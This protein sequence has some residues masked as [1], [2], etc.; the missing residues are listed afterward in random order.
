MRQHKP[1]RSTAVA[2]SNK[3]LKKDNACMGGANVIINPRRMRDVNSTTSTT[4]SATRIPIRTERAPLPPPFLSQ[5]LIVGDV[6]YCSGQVGADST[7]KLVEGSIQDRTVSQHDLGTICDCTD[8]HSDKSC[9]TSMPSLR[10]ED[11]AFI[12][13][14]KST[15]S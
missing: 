8:R 4:M 10:P 9:A 2:P 3:P 11:R 13:P 7:G 1:G 6:V 14:S 12:M 5:G 15:S